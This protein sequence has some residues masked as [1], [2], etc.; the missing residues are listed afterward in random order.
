MN[1][2][3]QFL[4]VLLFVFIGSFSLSAGKSKLSHDVIGVWQVPG[5]GGETAY[6]KLAEN[7]SLE[8]N[9]PPRPLQKG[10]WKIESNNHG[11]TKLIFLDENNEVI[12]VFIIDTNNKKNTLALLYENG[13]KMI[14]KRKE[15][16]F[17]QL[18]KNREV[19][20]KSSDWEGKLSESNNSPHLP[21]QNNDFS[22]PSKKWF[23]KDLD[24]K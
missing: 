11:E 22:K 10:M 4:L 24:P 5:I 14:L 7:H 9:I 2:Y 20:F 12:N 19:P 17:V 16:G 8:V 23:E 13:K 6:I 3:Y 1:K 21:E 18:D 15:Q